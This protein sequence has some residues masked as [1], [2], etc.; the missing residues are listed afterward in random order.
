M[1]S[2]ILLI[3]DEAKL[4]RFTQLELDCEGYQTTVAHATVAHDGL[5]GLTVARETA[6][7]LIVLDWMLPGVT[8]LEICRRL[9]STGN[10]VLIILQPCSGD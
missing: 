7:D 8:G 4:A 9:R 1:S 6:Y 2:S 5:T 10:K 3:E